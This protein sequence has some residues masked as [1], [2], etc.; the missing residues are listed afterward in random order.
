MSSSDLVYTLA[1]TCVEQAERLN[2][3]PDEVRAWVEDTGLHHELL[4]QLFPDFEQEGWTGD[5]YGEALDEAEGD[6]L[7]EVERLMERRTQ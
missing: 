1:R 3:G 5:E 7:I 6:L 4:D 2:L